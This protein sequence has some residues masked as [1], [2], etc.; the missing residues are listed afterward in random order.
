[1]AHTLCSISN[2]SLLIQL[3][4][5]L[6]FSVFLL[7][8]AKRAALYIGWSQGRWHG[9]GGAVPQAPNTKLSITHSF[10]E[11]QS[12]DFA[13]KFVWTVRKNTKI[14]KKPLRHQLLIHKKRKKCK[15]IR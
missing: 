7:A 12:P 2:T 8:G 15:K 6:N 3:Q 1:M 11:L 13:W 9:G 5:V 10:L 4:C 14:Q